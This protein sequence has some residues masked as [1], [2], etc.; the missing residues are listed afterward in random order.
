MPRK[1]QASLA[2]V[3]LI[4]AILLNSRPTLGEYVTAASEYYRRA[5]T[6]DS[7]AK[8]R[9]QL[10]LGAALGRS[11]KRAIEARLPGIAL[12]AREVPVAGALRIVRSDVTEFHRLD[13]LRLGV[14]VKPVNLAVGRAIWNRFGDIRTFAV[15]L[16]L[17][18]PF[19]VIGG[20][21][22]VPTTEWRD[23]R[24][25][26]TD[27]LITRAVARLARGG[28]R[29]SEAEAPHL[30]EGVALVAYDP[31]TGTLSNDLP[32]VGSGLR[33]DEFIGAMVTA[34]V[35]RFEGVEEALEDFELDLDAGAS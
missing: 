7:G 35:A 24:E 1:P 29:R 27:Q 20:I 18:F 19:A 14:E 15:N 12:E 2:G 9:A 5:A 32:P 31:A 30:L 21:L 11:C 6:L 13:G 22:A 28:G 33:W 3:P 10:V 34:Y 4:E 25:L 16:H 23:G 26:K 17:K 8:K